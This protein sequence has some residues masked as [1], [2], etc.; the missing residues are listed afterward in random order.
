MSSVYLPKEPLRRDPV[1]K[2]LI[3]SHDITPA[4][5]YGEIKILLPYSPL[6]FSTEPMMDALHEGLKTF[7]DSDY[8]VAIGDPA[9]IAAAIMVA[10]HINQGRVR[11]LRWDRLASR[12]LPL[13]YDVNKRKE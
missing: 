9:V 2:Q 4:M 8:I 13:H 12:Y 5:Q 10:S 6:M 11:L 7:S 3:A 1:S